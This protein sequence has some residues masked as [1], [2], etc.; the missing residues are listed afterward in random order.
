MT[1]WTG[2]RSSTGLAHPVV[3]N[4]NRNRN[5]PRPRLHGST[6]FVDSAPASAISATSCSVPWLRTK[7]NKTERK[8]RGVQKSD[9]VHQRVTITKTERSF[10]FPPRKPSVALCGRALVSHSVASGNRARP[11]PRARSRDRSVAF[12]HFDQFR[13]S[14]TN[15]DRKKISAPLWVNFSGDALLA[16]LPAFCGL[17]A[18][19][20]SQNRKSQNPLGPVTATFGQLW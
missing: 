9:V 10:S 17:F 12:R 18:H 19:R 2:H 5:R 6:S 4:R 11:R 13:P 1:L 3:P 20:K 7:L 16:P 8:R 14:S 15:F